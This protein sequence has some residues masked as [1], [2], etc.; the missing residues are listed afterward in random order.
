MTNRSLLVLDNLAV[1][2]LLVVLD[3]LEEGTKVTLSEAAA[4]GLLAAVREGAAE[5][6]DDLDEE[7]RAVK[8]GLGEDL[9]EAA[10]LIAVDKNVVLTALINELLS[11]HIAHLLGDVVLI[12]GGAGVA[13]KLNAALNASGV[14][15][16]HGGEDVVGLDGDVLDAGAAVVLEEGLNLA[17]AAGAVGGLVNGQE[18]RVEVVGHDHGVEARV[19]GTNVLGGELAELVEAKHSVEVLGEVVED[20]HVGDN[21]IDALEAKR[22]LR[23]LSVAVA[24]EEGALVLVAA[25]DEADDNVGVGEDLSIGD[26]AVVVGDG[27]GGKVSLTIVGD[28]LLI[29]VGGTLDLK[30]NGADGDAVAL[31]E[32]LDGLLIKGGEGLDTGDGGG[33]GIS[34]VRGGENKANIVTVEAVGGVL[35]VAS[36]NIRLGDHLKAKGGR[37]SAGDV[38]G[39]VAPELQV[40]EVLNLRAISHR[41]V[42]HEV[43]IANHLAGGGTRLGHVDRIES[44]SSKNAIDTWVTGSGNLRKKNQKEI[45]SSE[46]SR[47]KVATFIPC[48]KKHDN[49]I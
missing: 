26:G 8:E 43:G 14:H 46:N 49:Q 27:G 2:E 5:A 31:D 15:L 12:I 9:K 44:E 21:V 4:A 30:A 34:V 42:A 37:E 17:L 47:P 48:A 11:D 38:G 35:V 10:L 1:A 22:D 45:R 16:L 25:L 13:H 7:S 19:G 39:V 32:G 41:V 6:L 33:G 24:G 28:G 29:G 18:D 23:A 36:V 20:G 40:I 3:R